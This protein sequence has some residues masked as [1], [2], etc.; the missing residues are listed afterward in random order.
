MVVYIKVSLGWF[1]LTNFDAGSS[2]DISIGGI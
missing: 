1:D 2:I